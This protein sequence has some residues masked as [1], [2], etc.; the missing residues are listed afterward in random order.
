[1]ADHDFA[2]PPVGNFLE[3]LASAAP[4]PGGGT[5]AAVAGAMGAALVEMLARLTLG[6]KKY[7]QHEELMQAVAEQAEQERAALLDLAAKDAGAY[8]V[9][10]AALKLPREP[11][12]ASIQRNEA[13]QAA[14]QQACEVPLEVM[15]HCLEVIGL[16][17][18]AVTYGNR[19][20][21]SDGAA[22]CEL[23]RAGLKI[24]A[25]NVKINLGSMTDEDYAETARTRMD[26]MM[27]MGLRAAAAVDGQ[28][29]ELLRPQGPA[30]A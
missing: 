12:A 20:A 18:Q 10:S 11:Q 26:E 30:K 22:G 24:A 4:T 16:A 6:K 29:E 25:W 17:R 3:Q 19:N 7:A 5:G 13:I 1:M 14:L 2:A 9:V 27:Y 28:V 21:A 23:A 8:D 15:A